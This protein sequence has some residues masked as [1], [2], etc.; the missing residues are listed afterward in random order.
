MA[1]LS[2]RSLAIAPFLAALALTGCEADTET[3]SGVAD[4]ASESAADDA[5]EPSEM[6]VVAETGWLTIGNDGAVQTTFFDPNGRYR[7]LRN[8]SQVAAGDW[9]Q[10][11]DGSLCFTPDGWPEGAPETCWETGAPESDGSV[12]ATDGAGKSISIKRVTYIAPA[13]GEGQDNSEETD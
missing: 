5:A 7:D 12:I 4:P 3:G 9:Q 8:N 6:L 10:R 1:I 2:H 11:A 13:L